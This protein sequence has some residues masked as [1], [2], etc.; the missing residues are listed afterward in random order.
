[1]P[2]G[3]YFNVLSFG[4]DFNYM[5]DNSK[6]YSDKNLKLALEEISKFDGDMGGT[7]LL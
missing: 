5:F 2:V 3:S 6:E 1:M 4:S 7:D